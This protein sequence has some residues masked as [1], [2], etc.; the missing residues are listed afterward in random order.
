MDHPSAEPD[1]AEALI[2]GYADDL[3]Q[4][5]MATLLLEQADAEVSRDDNFRKLLVART[6]IGSNITADEN[7]VVDTLVISRTSLMGRRCPG[8]HRTGAAPRPAPVA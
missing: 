7:A 8:M 4:L 2:G 6:F 1:A 5:I 3:A